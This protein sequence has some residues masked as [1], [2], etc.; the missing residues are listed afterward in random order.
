MVDPSDSP[1]LGVERPGRNDHSA[2]KRP[3]Q[4]RNSTT[5]WACVSG[6]IGSAPPAPA[7]SP[8]GR[9]ARQRRARKGDPAAGDDGAS[10]ASTAPP[11]VV[12]VRQADESPRSRRC[13]PGARP[14]LADHLLDLQSGELAP[15]LPPGRDRRRGGVSRVASV[16]CHPERDA[17]TSFTP[18]IRSFSRTLPGRRPDAL[19]ATTTRWAAQ[20]P[21]G[22]PCPN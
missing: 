5:R 16:A 18:M 13:L 22:P 15:L 4:H 12:E 20:G 8:A 9:R 3:R 14:D 1:G 7:R 2:R 6:P 17:S 11:P 21:R 19:R 10:P